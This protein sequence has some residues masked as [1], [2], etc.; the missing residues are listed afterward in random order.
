VRTLH[1]DIDGTVLVLNTGRAKSA[2]AQGALERAVRAARFDQLAC[3]GNFAGVVRAM[4]GVRP[5]YDGLGVL[6]ALCA[7]CFH[8]EAWFRA[9]TRFVAD[10]RLRAAEVDLAEDWRYVDDQAARY[11][12]QAGRAEVFRTHVGDR[13]FV[14]DPLGD[15]TDILAWLGRIAG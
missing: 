11:F 3:V 1:F 13:I 5:D 7:D 6:F 10:P 2:L 12:E 14:P 9:T 4:A 8:D 15:G